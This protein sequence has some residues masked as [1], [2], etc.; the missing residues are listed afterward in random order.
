MKPEQASNIIND[1]FDEY[2]NGKVDS[3]LKLIPKL[4]KNKEALIV[5]RNKFKKE[6]Q[7]NRSGADTYGFKNIEEDLM[8]ISDRWQCQFRTQWIIDMLD[9]LNEEE[10]Q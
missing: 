2:Y 9:Y 10:K 7:D 6:E 3:V 5:M 8:Y 1:I 4:R